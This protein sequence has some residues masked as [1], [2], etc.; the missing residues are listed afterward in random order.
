MAYQFPLGEDNSKYP[1]KVRFRARELKPVDITTILGAATAFS[2]EIQNIEELPQEVADGVAA[3][4]GY[5][6]ANTNNEEDNRPTETL[7]TGQIAFQD[8]KDTITLYLP[9]Q[10][11]IADGISYDTNFSMGVLG[12]GTQAALEQGE[13][14]VPAVVG[15]VKNVFST[16]SEAFSEKGARSNTARLGIGQLAGLVGSQVQGAVRS[17]T[18]VTT[19]PNTQSLF[20]NV[21]LREFTFQLKMIPSS[22]EETQVI[23]NIIKAF[24]T[25]MYPEA[26]E[27]AG[28]P[29][30]FVFPNI[31]EIDI[32]YGTTQKRL[33]TRIL[34]SYLRSFNTTYNSS[35]MGFLEG[36]DFS[37]VDI[38][39]SFV[40][41][42]TLN[43][44]RI[45]EGY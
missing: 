34:P 33:A 30:G 8:V 40:E 4:I 14:L 2:Q 29:A 20:Q 38:T 11:Q 26:F 22:I 42:R 31:F 44:K 21:N 15:G 45:E 43:R 41:S 13:G 37:E 28:V 39:M 6:F 5:G 27:V 1:A 36:G 23:K 3:D 18:L 16:Y 32:F 17:G 24:R 35:G 9:Q 7:T 19:N 25:N 10:L 12:R